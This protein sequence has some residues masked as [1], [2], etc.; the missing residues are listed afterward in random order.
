MPEI[1]ITVQDLAEAWPVLEGLSGP[2]PDGQKIKISP[3]F[4]LA[5]QRNK[6]RT[7]YEIYVAHR[8]EIFKKFGHEI[9]QE[10]QQP[11]P[12]SDE[13]KVK[14]ENI[15]AANAEIKALLEGQL[16]VE[17]EPRP[18]TYLGLEL[19]PAQLSALHFLLT[20]PAEPAEPK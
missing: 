15:G 17:V 12:G 16:T 3:S 20:E 7:P 13:W 19:L 2:L 14:P 8:L 5:H 10:T 6:L 4:W 9:N 18:A 11:E 1:R